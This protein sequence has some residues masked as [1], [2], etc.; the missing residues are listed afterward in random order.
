MAT[1]NWAAQVNDAGWGLGVWNADAFLFGGGFSGLPG[2]GGPLDNPTGY[3]APTRTEILDHNIVYDYHYELILGT[4][5][6]I[7][8]H[9]Y[10]NASRAAVRS[11]QFTQDRQGWYFDDA[12]DAGWPIRGELDVRS[13]EGKAPH[14]ISPLFFIRAETA[15][16]LIIE[17]AFATGRSE[18]TVWWRRSDSQGFV[19]AQAQDFAVIPD[20]LFRRYEINLGAAPE[21]RGI[22]TQLRLDVLPAG[23]QTAHVRLKSVILG[24]GALSQETNHVDDQSKA[25]R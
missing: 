10:R 4:V 7:R 2:D 15:P 24:T 3:I 6:E 14:I 8:A 12:S 18:A 19:R 23:H 9:V 17:A 11:F 20:G 1:E 5:D 21:Y 13:E 25:A 16:K 22:I